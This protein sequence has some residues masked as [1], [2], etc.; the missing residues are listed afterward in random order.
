MW[1]SNLKFLIICWNK[2]LKSIILHAELIM[3]SISMFLTVGNPYIVFIITLVW[4]F[5]EKNKGYVWVQANEA[6]DL[7][8]VWLISHSTNWGQIMF[9]VLQYYTCN[10]VQTSLR[11]NKRSKFSQK[12]LPQT[13]HGMMRYQENS[14]QNYWSLIGFWGSHSGSYENCHLLWYILL[15][16]FL[17]YVVGG[18]NQGPLDTTAT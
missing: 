3:Q 11:G 9:N 16:F 10:T 4:T 13:L 5:L 7:L 14:G 2:N 15:F 12:W 6:V 17:I 1:N 8:M 18:W